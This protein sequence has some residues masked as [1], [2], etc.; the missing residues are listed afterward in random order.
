ML[1][2]SVSAVHEYVHQG[3][4]KDQ[5]VGQ[6]A[7]C[8]RKVFGPQQKAHEEQ[9]DRAHEK[10]A[11]G[12]ET[13][14]CA[15]VV[16]MLRMVAHGHVCSPIIRRQRPRNMPIEQANGNSPGSLGKSSMV[17][18]SP[19]GRSALLLNSAKITLMRVKPLQPCQRRAPVA[20]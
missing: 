7:H 8:V 6:K 13:T 4:C 1:V 20:H 19:A 3:T 11:R 18:V 5:E 10:R 9:Q 2:A 15:G 12:P 17:T 16:M 14:V